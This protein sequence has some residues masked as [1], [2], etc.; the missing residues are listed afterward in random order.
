MTV[1]TCNQNPHVI[2]RELAGIFKASIADVRVIVFTLGG[3]FGGKLNP[4]LE[5]AAVSLPKKTGRP[6]RIA[7]RRAECFLLGV[8]REG[9]TRLKT[10]VNRD[11]PLMAVEVRW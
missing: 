10:G 1:W 4:K 5:P 9:K 11:G 8:H 7:A 2:Q 3:G 6:V